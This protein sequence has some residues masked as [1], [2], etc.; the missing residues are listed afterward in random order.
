[1]LHKLELR[2][3]SGDRQDRGVTRR[4]PRTTD[5]S[6]PSGRI[7]SLLSRYNETK[8]EFNTQ[9]DPDCQNDHVFALKWSFI[10][11]FELAP[12]AMASHDGSDV[13]LRLA[14]FDQFQGYW[15]HYVNL[16]TSKR[17]ALGKLVS[18]AVPTGVS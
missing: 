16:G 12:I 13:F 11:K 2:L 14:N 10:R 8:R 15:R 6:F 3:I 9:V 17:S 1:M 18:L 4:N 5:K 7:Y